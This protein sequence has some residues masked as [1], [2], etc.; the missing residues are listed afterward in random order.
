MKLIFLSFFVFFK[1]FAICQNYTEILLNE[2]PQ[3]KTFEQDCVKYS[4]RANY[5]DMWIKL[6]NVTNVSKIM[7]TDKLIENCEKT[8][9]PLNSKF[10]Q[11]IKF[12]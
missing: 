5:K 3:H 11:C 6:L 7:I 1:F 2:M 10:C 9:C 4:L 8:E 12:S